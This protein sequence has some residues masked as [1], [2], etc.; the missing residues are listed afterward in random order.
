MT[1][2]I[3]TSNG[4]PNNGT[5]LKHIATISRWANGN[6]ELNLVLWD[7]PINGSRITYDY[8]LW[9]NDTVYHGG[10]LHFSKYE[11][12]NFAKAYESIK[13]LEFDV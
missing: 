2:I 1:Q 4:E 3:I 6:Y 12:E 9:E 8:R 7:K 5:I 11:L 13:S 10:G